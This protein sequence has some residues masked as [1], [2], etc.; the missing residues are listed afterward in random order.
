MLLAGTNFLGMVVFQNQN[1]SSFMF[2][3]CQ[4]S[5]YNLQQSRYS[6]LFFASLL[7]TNI[8]SLF[9]K[10]NTLVTL[11]SALEDNSAGLSEGS[12]EWLLAFLY[13]GGA[14]LFW[15][16]RLAG[17]VTLRSPQSVD[18]LQQRTFGSAGSFAALFGFLQRVTPPGFNVGLNLGLMSLPLSLQQCCL[19]HA[20]VDALSE[21][22]PCRLV[23][24]AEAW[25][26]GRC[27]SFLLR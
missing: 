9:T 20:A 6:C 7:N 22:D 3:Y 4:I 13:F 5:L 2:K 8:L 19:L 26:M 16:G 10:I 23:G 1:W 14:I 18:L 15:V 21:R 12:V 11:S 27:I 17:T 25:Y 24:Y